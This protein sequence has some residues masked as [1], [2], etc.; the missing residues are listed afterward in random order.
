MPDRTS[1]NRI[2][3]SDRP[4]EVIPQDHTMTNTGESAAGTRQASTPVPQTHHEKAAR[5]ASLCTHRRFRPGLSLLDSTTVLEQIGTAA[6][7]LTLGNVNRLATWICNVR[8]AG[9]RSATLTLLRASI[10]YLQT[11]PT[12]TDNHLSVISCI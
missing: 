10:R 8:P 1:F 2:V 3:G 5:P 6:V 12:M 7:P 11:F 4:G 9:S